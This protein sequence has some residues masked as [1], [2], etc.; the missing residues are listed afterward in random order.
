M[1]LPLA[2][3]VRGLLR[4]S[5]AACSPFSH[6]NEK[7]AAAG[8]P[9]WLTLGTASCL[10][11]CLLDFLGFSRIR[12]DKSKKPRLS[13]APPRRGTRNRCE[14]VTGCRDNACR[15]SSAQTVRVFRR[16]CRRSHLRMCP[17]PRTFCAKISRQTRSRSRRGRKPLQARTATHA[18][19]LMKRRDS[20]ALTCGVRKKPSQPRYQERAHSIGVRPRT[21]RYSGLSL[22]WARGCVARADRSAVIDQELFNSILCSRL[23]ARVRSGWVQ[24]GAVPKAFQALDSFR[25]WAAHR[26]RRAVVS[27]SVGTGLPRQLRPAYIEKSQTSKIRNWLLIHYVYDYPPALFVRS[28]RIE[29][30]HKPVAKT[31]AEILFNE[32]VSDQI[33]VQ[34]ARTQSAEKQRAI[35]AMIGLAPSELTAGKGGPGRTGGSLVTVGWTAFDGCLNGGTCLSS[36]SLNRPY[37][38]LSPVLALAS[39]QARQPR[40]RSEG[41]YSQRVLIVTL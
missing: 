30:T 1:S 28:Q 40:C 36:L 4:F 26:P 35:A 17:S 7:R 22:A 16:L 21:G 13:C 15:T 3:A 2:T 25:V 20:R 31:V 37:N 41:V 34:L 33:D 9:C 24:L 18:Q 11:C 5:A 27:R 32:I 19:L 38:H 12:Q 10:P 29:L 14:S 39:G 23:R 8:R 6:A